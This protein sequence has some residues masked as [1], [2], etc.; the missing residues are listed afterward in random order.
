MLE[1]T[2]MDAI[3]S[4]FDYY[5]L[6]IKNKLR[7]DMGAL[8]ATFAALNKCDALIAQAR[9]AGVYTRDPPGA[10]SSASPVPSATLGPAAVVT[11]LHTPRLAVVLARARARGRGR[12][13][14]RASP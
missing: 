14:G 13:R 1:A 8:P 9:V 7:S 4:I 12:G 10:I 2:N 3:Y 11:M 6:Q 5:T